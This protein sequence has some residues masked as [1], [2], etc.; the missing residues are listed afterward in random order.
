MLCIEREPLTDSDLAYIAFRLAC[1]ETLERVA[2]AEQMGVAG[3]GAFGY[4]A[5][6]PFLRN[7]APQV[8]LDLLFE[9]W[10]KLRSEE[11][12]AATLID[13]SIVYA[14]CE[15]AARSVENDTKFAARN[16]T[17]GPRNLRGALS[18]T[19]ADQ[20]RFVHLS[21]PNEGHFLLIS[22]FQDID[23]DDG[24]KLKSSFGLDPDS[25][26][27]MFDAL[28]RW[29]VSPQFSQNAEGLLDANEAAQAAQILGL[30]RTVS[31]W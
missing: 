2:L 23:P 12:I 5:E 28:G 6:V 29:H 3:D 24:R 31:P 17:D 16:L 13:E 22:Q 4:L 30:N 18:R 21:L 26:E 14:A 10:A 25:C 9:C 27:P 11:S 19:L 1:L 15:V 8:Q 20:L 7:V